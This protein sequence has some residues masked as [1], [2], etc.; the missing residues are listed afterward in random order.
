[1][2][3]LDLFREDFENENLWRDVCDVVK[4]PYSA[5]SISIEFT[6]V[7]YEYSKEDDLNPINN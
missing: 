7:S 3:V 5:E 2:N 1:M 6:K 4:A